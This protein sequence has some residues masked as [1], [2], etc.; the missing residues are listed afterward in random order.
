[1]PEPAV[2]TRAL[3]VS[4]GDVAAVRGLDLSVAAGRATALVGRNGAGKSTTLKVLAGV[5]PATSGDRK[6][7]V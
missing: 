5:V 2:V 6:S 4:F 1:M 7:V 3:T